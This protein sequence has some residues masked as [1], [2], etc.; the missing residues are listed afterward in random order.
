MS[1]FRYSEMVIVMQ[2]I[3]LAVASQ[4]LAELIEAAINGEEIII[5]KDELPV[6]KLTPVISEKKFRRQPGSAKGL[7]TIADDFDAP[8]NEEFKDYM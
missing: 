2:Q 7:I 8:L 4:K 6:V 5:T 1:Q 3:T